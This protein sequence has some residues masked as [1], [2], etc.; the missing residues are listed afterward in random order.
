MDRLRVFTPSAE[1]QDAEWAKWRDIDVETPAQLSLKET[2]QFEPIPDH[3]H[4]GATF[5]GIAFGD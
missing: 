1:R 2:V 5:G 3:T 4:S